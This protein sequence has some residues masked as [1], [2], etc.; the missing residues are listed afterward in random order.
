MSYIL[1]LNYILIFIN[2]TKNFNI[3]KSVYLRLNNKLFI[4][5]HYLI[6]IPVLLLVQIYQ[7]LRN[8]NHIFLE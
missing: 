5:G 6:S 4:F 8:M 1:I 2:T 3:L 7:L